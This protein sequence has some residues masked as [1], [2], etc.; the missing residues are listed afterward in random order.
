MPMN[1][2]LLSRITVKI[3][4]AILA[5]ALVDL[6]YIN[7]WIAKSDNLRGSN[8]TEVNRSVNLAPSASPFPTPTPDMPKSSPVVTIVESKTVVERETQTIVQTAQKE[9]FIP[10]GSG[11]TKSS[12]YTDLAGLSVTIDT[13]KY[14]AIDSVIF[15]A[16]GW[17]DGGNGKAFA[18]LYNK[19][20]GHPVWNSEISTSSPNGVLL[21]SSKIN[22]D[23][24]NKTYTVW[25]KTNLVEFAAH[26]DNARIKITLK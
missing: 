10:I 14:S 18:Q 13:S 3:G 17:V 24:G 19:T 2:S 21:D 12:N 16:S 22:L 25:A 15:E 4:I 1:D 23:S 6:V 8:Q 26:A 5:L 20:D 9:I 11:S 7:Y